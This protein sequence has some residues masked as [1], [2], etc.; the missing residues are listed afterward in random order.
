MTNNKALRVFLMLFCIFSLSLIF[1]VIDMP[2]SDAKSTPFNLGYAVGVALGNM[3]KI[4]VT[5]TIAKMAY[6]T[7]KTVSELASN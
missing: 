1:T 3:I 5:L 6:V 7:M 4:L 2:F